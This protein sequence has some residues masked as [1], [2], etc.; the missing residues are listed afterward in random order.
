MLENVAQFLFI[1]AAVVAVFAFLSVASWASIRADERKTLERYALLRKLAEQPTETARVIL[2][3]LREEE[4]R[5]RQARAARQAE[6]WLERLQG[7]FIVVAVGVGLMV[8]LE[9][10]EPQRGLWT[11]GLIPAFVGVV[12]IFF[13]YFTRRTR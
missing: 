10:L 2:E 13:A 9:A 3:E 6:S 5:R 8:M 1:G 7:G 11:V 12:L 4:E